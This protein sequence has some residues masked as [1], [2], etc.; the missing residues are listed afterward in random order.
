MESKIVLVLISPIDEI[1]RKVF[2]T[3]IK[4]SQIPVESTHRNPENPQI[5]LSA[6]LG[7]RS[8]SDGSQMQID[9]TLTSPDSLASHASPLDTSLKIPPP[10]C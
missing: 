4:G 6:V 3:I 1:G 7:Y 9:S 8:K 10:Q 2:T 5:L